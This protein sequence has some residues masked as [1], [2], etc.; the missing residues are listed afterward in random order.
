MLTTLA[1]LF[2]VWLIAAFVFHQLEQRIPG[3][4]VL[5]HY[6]TG[7]PH[8]RGYITDVIWAIINGP[9]LSGLEK[10]LFAAIVAHLPTLQGW[11]GLDGWPWWA[12]FALFFVA[13]DCMRYWLHRAYHELDFLWRIHRV[14]HTVTEMDAMSVFRLHTL[15]AICKNGLIFLPFRLCGIDG[16]VMVAYTCLDIIKGYWHHANLRTHIGPLNYLFNSPELHWWHHAVDSRGQMSNFGSILSIWDWLFRTGYWPK[17]RWPQQIG[18]AGMENFPT[19]FVG[20]LTSIAHDDASATRRYGTS[21]AAAGAKSPP[22]L[23]ADAA[24]RERP[25]GAVAVIP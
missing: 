25:D 15:E 11:A 18:V 7:L 13:N 4:N 3:R 17:G 9:G 2:G 14:H 21:A 16:S 10:A 1:I 19:D 24:A 22:T 23:Q 20:Q 5:A 12:Q 8:R 6:R